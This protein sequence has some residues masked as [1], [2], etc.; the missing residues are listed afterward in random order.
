M[1]YFFT[2]KISPFRMTFGTDGTEAAIAAVVTPAQPVL[3]N[4]DTAN[5]GFCLN[6]QE[7]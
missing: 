6:F 2:A 5:T 4:V 7:K 1:N 3:Q